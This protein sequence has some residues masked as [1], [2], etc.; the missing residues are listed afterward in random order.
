MKE[1]VRYGFILALICLVAAGL[2]CAVNILTRARIISQAMAEEQIS[3]KE[4]MPQAQEFQPVKKTEEVVYYKAI[5]KDGKFIG[6]AFK[7]QSKGYSSI[8]ETMVGMT[9]DGKITA[10]KIL[11]QNET[12][13]LG[14]QVSGSDFTG[15]FSKKSLKEFDQIDT[16]TGATISSSAVINAVKA[17]AAELEALIKNEK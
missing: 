15:Q 14:S 17:K 6:A 9:N 16:I 5:D 12:P 7:V 8:I 10:I 4:V 13:G 11:S 2:L 1:M 3:L